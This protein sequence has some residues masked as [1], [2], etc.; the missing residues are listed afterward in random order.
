MLQVTPLLLGSFATVAV[1]SWLPLVRRLAVAGTTATE[2]AGPPPL[3]AIE[4]EPQAGT[5]NRPNAMGSRRGN[6][7]VFMIDPIR[8][9]RRLEAKATQRRRPEPSYSWSSRWVALAS[10]RLEP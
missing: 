8:G 10:S 1:K 7:S 2:I 5:R 6:G 9:S 3:G 4:S